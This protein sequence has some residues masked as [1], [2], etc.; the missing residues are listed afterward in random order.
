MPEPRPATHL[1]GAVGEVAVVAERQADRAQK[2][3][4]PT[5][6]QRPREGDEEDQQRGGRTVQN[7]AIVKF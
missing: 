4:P 7:T 6:R 1:K 5:G 3:K 2:V